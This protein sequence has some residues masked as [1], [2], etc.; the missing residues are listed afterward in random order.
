MNKRK[1]Y[2]GAV[3]LAV[4]V[5]MGAESALASISAAERRAHEVYALRTEA[6]VGAQSCRMLDRFNAFATKFS[7]ELTQEGR[8]LRSY[9]QK[10]HGKRGDSELDDFVTQLSNKTFASTGAAPEFCAH[11][12][13]LFDNLL[14]L[15]VGQL[16]KFSGARDVTALPAMDVCAPAPRPAA[17]KGRS[18]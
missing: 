2:V 8:A 14:A 13:A 15:P 7:R 18:S 4:S 16:A 6:I 3:A 5:S 10:M 12:S 1:L 17:T 9:F 11:T